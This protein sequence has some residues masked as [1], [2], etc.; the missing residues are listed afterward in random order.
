[1]SSLFFVQMI[2]NIKIILKMRKTYGNINDIENYIQNCFWV[3]E[4]ELIMLNILL[5][6]TA[7]VLFV[8]LCVIYPLGI[9]RF[10]EKSK[11]KQRKSV[12]CFLRK[13]H[14]KMGVWIIVVSLLHGIVEIKAGNLDGMFSGKICFLLLILLWLSYG[15]KRVLK[16]KWMIVHRILAVLTVIAVIV[17]VGGM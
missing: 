10:L 4:K 9:L 3:I 12:D 8:L 16:E 1:M 13:I 7:T 11:E 14:K 5:S 6:V 2:I 15:L 17:H